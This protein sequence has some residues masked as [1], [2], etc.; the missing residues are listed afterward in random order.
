MTSA[1]RAQAP[2]AGW[3]GS[4]EGCRRA[5]GPTEARRA[6]CPDPGTTAPTARP[7]CTRRSG[8]HSRRSAGGGSVRGGRNMIRVRESPTV[9]AASTYGRVALLQRRPADEADV[10]RPREDEQHA[11]RRRSSRRR[12]LP[13]QDDHHEQRRE[14]VHAGRRERIDRRVAPSRRGTRHAGRAVHPSSPPRR[15]SPRVP[16]TACARADDDAAR[17][18]RALSRRCRAGAP[19]SATEAQR[20]IVHE[21]VV[22]GEQLPGHRARHDDRDEDHASDDDERHAARARRRPQRGDVDWRAHAAPRPRRIRGS[23]AT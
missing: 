10:V 19:R 13:T 12:S 18:C 17:G 22:R 20:E 7:G 1:L 4:A 6:N 2:P 5:S 21:G 3:I 11:D 9:R 14:R 23:T 15:R 8:T 16:T